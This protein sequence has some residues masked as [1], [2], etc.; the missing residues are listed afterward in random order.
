LRWGK[1]PPDYFAY[2]LETES[3]TGLELW[4]FKGVSAHPD[5]YQDIMFR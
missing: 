3:V 5:R 1:N 4:G 2:A